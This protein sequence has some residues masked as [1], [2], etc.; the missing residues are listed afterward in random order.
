MGAPAGG[1]GEAESGGQPGRVRAVIFDYGNVLVGWSPRTLYAGLIPE[2]DRLER[3]LRDVCPLSWHRLHDSGVPMG[4]TIPRRQ[5]E[6]PEFADEI[7]A[8]KTR[9]GEMITGPI[10][11][12]VALAR[13]LKTAGVPMA[14]LT[15]MPSEMVETCFGPFGLK[16][17]FDAIVVSG[18][19]GCAKPD[20][21]IYRLAL[22]RLGG[23]A[24][25]AVLFVDDMP[26]NI[27][28]ARALGFEVHLF[29]EPDGLARRMR[30]LGLPA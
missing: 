25:E 19:E 4:V 3:F 5:A 24:P 23:L 2:P 11:G 26:D 13:R 29:E 22:E 8:W 6:F 16:P 12:T 15:N 18:D 10:A 27:E 7:A 17:L 9:F 14:V 21:A 20:P 28:A 1:A 30:A